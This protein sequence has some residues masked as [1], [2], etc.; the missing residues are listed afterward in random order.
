MTG[1]SAAAE[2]ETVAG[3]VAARSYRPPRRSMWTAAN[4]PQRPATGFGGD[5]G[6]CPQ[7]GHWS[8]EGDCLN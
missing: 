3:F 2:I 1:D 6:S 7:S 4:R 8:E 5:G